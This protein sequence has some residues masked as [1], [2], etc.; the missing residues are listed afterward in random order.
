MLSCVCRPVT[1]THFIKPPSM[2]AP[3]ERQHVVTSEPKIGMA[4]TM[5]VKQKVVHNKCLFN[6][7]FLIMSFY[8]SFL[9]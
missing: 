3:Q 7:F 1:G 6:N 9:I 4:K 8:V 2:G 5:I